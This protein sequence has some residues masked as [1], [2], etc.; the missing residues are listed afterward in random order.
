[1][2]LHPTIRGHALGK[3]TSFNYLQIPGN[4]GMP[5]DPTVDYRVELVRPPLPIG[6]QIWAAPQAPL[7]IYFRNATLDSFIIFNT[8]GALAVSPSYGSM[9][10][11]PAIGEIVQIRGLWD[12]V[13]DMHSIFWRAGV[14]GG[15]DLADDTGWNL[16]AQVQ[17]LGNS[18]N[19]ASMASWFLIGTTGFNTSI[20]P[21]YRWVRKV[22]GV[23]DID[24]DLRRDVT[25]A[26]KNAATITPHVG[27]NV[28]VTKYPNI[29]S[30]TFNGVGTT[31][32]ELI[33][34]AAL[35]PTQDVLLV[36]RA[37]TNWGPAMGL[38]G[39]ADK[40]VGNGTNSWRSFLSNNTIQFYWSPDGT[41][42]SQLTVT[43]AAITTVI[44]GL[45]AGQM[46]W[47]ATVFDG[48]NGTGGRTT[49]FYVSTTDTDDFGQVVW[50]LLSTVTTAGVTSIHNGTA[51]VMLNS[52]PFPF[53]GTMRYF[54]ESVAI[55]TG[56]PTG[57]H[58]MSYVM[59]RRSTF[60]GT[61]FLSTNGHAISR[62]G[63]PTI[64]MDPTPEILELFPSQGSYVGDKPVQAAFMG[65]TAVD[66]AYWTPAA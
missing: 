42:A 15:P 9:V 41:D 56:A 62:V 8:G 61:T 23:I 18:I 37:S 63:A 24:F 40:R 32:L 33:D 66:T 6:S 12:A 2:K 38:M 21:V 43:S 31:R 26:N 55:P 20:T 17:R 22:N 28:S 13:S 48:N 58:P 50:T 47:W 46:I 60:N 34:N 39:V 54:G 65:E 7:Y 36:H 59:D 19:P 3:G 10:G 27:P 35:D 4:I 57:A 44:P 49:R 45:T 5:A 52:L 16:G 1:M 25:E 64:N 53:T 14:G 51:N 11:F 29:E 30:V